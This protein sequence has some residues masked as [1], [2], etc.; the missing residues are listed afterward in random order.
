MVKKH[1][2]NLMGRAGLA[3]NSSKAY[4]ELIRELCIELGFSEHVVQLRWGNEIVVYLS[5]M[6]LNIICDENYVDCIL[7]TGGMA[8]PGEYV[9]TVFH[10]T[11]LM[12]P[13]SIPE[14]A[15]KLKTYVPRRP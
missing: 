6:K 12:N 15:E 13:S 10:K 14:I 2:R 11:N 7:L 8:M 9:N 4:A 1:W 5:G 3:S